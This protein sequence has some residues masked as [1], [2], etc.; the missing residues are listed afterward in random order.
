MPVSSVTTMKN[1]NKMK[2]G[3]GSSLAKRCNDFLLLEKACADYVNKE[4][5]MT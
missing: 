1:K 4:L 3:D 5:I 2:D